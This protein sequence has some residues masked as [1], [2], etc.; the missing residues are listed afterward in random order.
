MPKIDPEVVDKLKQIISG[1]PYIKRDELSKRLGLRGGDSLDWHI[2]E[3]ARDED[4][5]ADI[6]RWLA[7]RRP[8]TTGETRTKQLHRKLR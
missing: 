2:A 4:Y 7:Y 5:R 1:N 6:D 3:A 8:Q